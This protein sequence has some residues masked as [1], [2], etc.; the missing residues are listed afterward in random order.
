MGHVVTIG[1]IPMGLKNTGTRQL[2]SPLLTTPVPLRPA[3]A[4]GVC[5]RRVLRPC[6][7]VLGPTVS[8]VCGAQTSST[9]ESNFRLYCSYP[10]D[11]SRAAVAMPG[12]PN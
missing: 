11:S 7:H 1:S 6:S 3:A 8:P 12:T 2:S 4:V 5:Y 9:F 10:S